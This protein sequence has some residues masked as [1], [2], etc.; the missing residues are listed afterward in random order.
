MEEIQQKLAT[1]ESERKTIFLRLEKL[2]EYKEYSENKFHEIETRQEVAHKEI[3]YWI[4]EAV[5]DGNKIMQK[6]FMEQAIETK[7]DI[8]KLKIDVQE[9]KDKPS[10]IIASNVFKYAGL[11]IGVMVTMLITFFLNNLFA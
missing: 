11:A 7:H 10:K 5:Q 2:E 4:K 8:N 1:A 9:L 6:W 3:P